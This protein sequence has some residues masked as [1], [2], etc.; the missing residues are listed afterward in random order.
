MKFRIFCMLMIGS[1]YYD[2]AGFARGMRHIIYTNFI[3]ISKMKTALISQR[4]DWT[5][6]Q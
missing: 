5:L 6:N 4:T 3:L 1:F 2:N